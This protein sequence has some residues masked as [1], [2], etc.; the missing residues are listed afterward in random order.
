MVTLQRTD[1]SNSDFLTLLPY[2][3][4]E[5]RENDG[6]EADY[7]ATF[8]KP[9]GIP[10]VVVAYENNTPVGCGALKPYKEKTVEVK[11]M[12]VP[13]ALRGKGISSKVLAELENW[14]REQ[15]FD[16]AILETGKT[17]T[18]AIT[19]Y[20]KKGYKIIP[21]YDQYVGVVNSICMQK[22]LS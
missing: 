2:L 21:N 8:N 7:Y 4:K 20:R 14:A 17:Q 12:F 16:T 15:G 3:D 9:Q 22:S 18:A 13:K 1:N 10:W 6:D 5:L 19:L 11:R